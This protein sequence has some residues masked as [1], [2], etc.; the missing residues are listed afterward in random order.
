[1]VGKSFGEEE[2]P[3]TV[4]R[5]VV[6]GLAIALPGTPISF[7]LHLTIGELLDWAQRYQE[8][9]REHLTNRG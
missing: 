3:E 5:Q 2:A 7:W 1:M 4:T 9:V 8:F 6:L